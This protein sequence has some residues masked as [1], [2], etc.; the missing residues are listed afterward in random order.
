MSSF[1]FSTHSAVI[2]LK[3]KR[4]KKK[5]YTVYSICVIASNGRNFF[6]E[7]KIGSLF[8]DAGHTMEAFLAP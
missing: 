2:N 1:S 8:L 7:G 5:K 3:K 4:K 6:P